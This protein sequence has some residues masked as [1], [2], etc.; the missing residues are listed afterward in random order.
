VAAN[1]ASGLNGMS[2]PASIRV[3]PKQG[4][5]MNPKGQPSCASSRKQD[6]KVQ[7]NIDSMMD[8]VQNYET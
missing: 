6:D 3:T 7:K 4:F 5:L 2:L 8:T 1:P